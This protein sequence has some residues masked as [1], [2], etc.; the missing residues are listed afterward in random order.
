MPLSDTPKRERDPFLEAV[1]R[2]TLAAGELDH[3][4]RSLLG[5]IAFEPTLIKYA[6]A[7]KTD[8]LIQ[9]CKLALTNGVIEPEGVD[10]ITKCLER[11]DRFRD[12]RNKIV[13][14]IYSQNESGTGIE[15]LN[16]VRKNLGYRATPISV[17]E[18]EALADEVA[19]LRS[20]MFRAG[21]NATAGKAPGLGTIPA[22][23]PGEF[24]NG[25]RIIAT[26]ATEA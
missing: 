6:N 5:S 1:G 24:V 12:R 18:M 7:A 23:K 11:A 22:P 17:E 13:H 10:E 2:I 9:F 25:V 8:Q 3:S 4:L 19:L 14:A 16:P 26:P 20:D 15:G 21:W